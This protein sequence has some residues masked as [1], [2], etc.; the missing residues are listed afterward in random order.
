M[1]EN[2]ESLSSEEISSLNIE[3]DKVVRK[4]ILATEHKPVSLSLDSFIIGGKL[5]LYPEVTGKGYFQV[6]LDKDQLVLQAGGYV[7]LIPINDHIAIDIRPRVPIQNLERILQI[8]DH[9]PVSLA[10]HQRTYGTNEQ[11]IPSLLDFLS[12]SL[13]DFMGDIEKNGLYRDYERTTDETS[14]PRG[15]ILLNN[16]VQKHLSRGEKH[17][18]SAS[19][20]DRTVDNPINRC[21]KYAIW[22]LAQKYSAQ[23]SR[24]G[25][26]QIVS[27]LNQVYA[28]LQGV[29]LDKTRSFLRDP[30]VQ[31]PH[32]LPSIRQYY[33]QPLYLATTI[34]RERGIQFSESGNEIILA[35][36][37]INLE[38]I[39]E[40][41]IRET[42]SL[43]VPHQQTG[44]AVLDGNIGGAR[45]AEKTLFD[46]GFLEDIATQN[47]A[48]PDIVVQW[49]NEDTGATTTRVVI[50]T[51]Y[52]IINAIPDRDDINQ[53][54]AY[55]VSYR[56]PY[57]VIIHPSVNSHKGLRSLGRINGLRVFLYTID[58]S[59]ADLELEEIEMATAICQ[60]AAGKLSLG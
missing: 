51:K 19:W 1:T 41:Y 60:I 43:R 35:S 42:L 16:T 15:R 47:K 39:F 38:N 24:K 54:I 37:I 7:G 23:E 49:V 12:R 59:I 11:T 13:I 55:A 21:L 26:R 44:Y 46:V 31:Y 14:F 34:I 2:N 40:S 58:L 57:A 10:P 52:K 32:A 4:V 48:N 17:R 53:V 30:Y 29:T 18:V 45:G 28:L 27:A 3:V 22:Y 56:A 50:D 25:T 36:F 5:N 8:V 33:L 20:F 6:K 9:T